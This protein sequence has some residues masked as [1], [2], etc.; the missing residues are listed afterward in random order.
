MDLLKATLED[1]CWF[2]MLGLLKVEAMKLLKFLN[3][4][5]LELVPWR[6]WAR[7]LVACLG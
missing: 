3:R 7:Y 4:D 5:L 6:D 2:I 1:Y